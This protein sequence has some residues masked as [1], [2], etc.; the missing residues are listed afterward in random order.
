VSTPKRAIQATSTNVEALVPEPSE[1]EVEGD[2]LATAVD[3]VA[4]MVGADG[5]GMATDAAYGQW[6]A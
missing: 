1:T 5:N 2:G 3:V 6:P 4:L